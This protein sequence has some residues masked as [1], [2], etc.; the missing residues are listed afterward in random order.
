MTISTALGTNAPTQSGRLNTTSVP[1]TCATPKAC[2]G[3]LAA[4]NWR[5][6]TL[7]FRN[8]PS[9][10][11]LSVTLNAPTASFGVAA[12]AYINSYDPGNVCGNY[13]ADV[14]PFADS[15][16]GPRAFSFAATSNATIVIVVYQTGLAATT[17]YTL[18]VSGGACRP[19]QY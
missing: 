8:G 1:S 6:D 17:P 5:Y 19:A 18:T 10:A 16:S 13:L 11:C 4:F 14:G 12:A 15:D 7:T 2:P 3:L 9:N